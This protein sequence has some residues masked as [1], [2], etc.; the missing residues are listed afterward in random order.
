MYPADL[1]I[2]MQAELATLADIEAAY[3]KKR[4]DLETWNATRQDW[5]IC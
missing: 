4:H 3:A 2:A 1:T 5:P